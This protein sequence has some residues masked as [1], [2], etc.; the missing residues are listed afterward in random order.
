MLARLQLSIPG[1]PETG[2]SRARWG[3][4]IGALGTLFQVV[5][6]LMIGY[7]RDSTAR[8]RISDLD[9]K[10][11]SGF[12]RAMLKFVSRSGPSRKHADLS[13]VSDLN[14]QL[15]VSCD[16]RVKIDALLPGL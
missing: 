11:S 15:E 3:V 1:N 10:G 4:F 16:R 12:W 14:G 8:Q 13:C 2:E 7:T 5:F 9:P 6:T